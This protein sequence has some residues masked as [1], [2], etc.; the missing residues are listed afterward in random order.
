MTSAS[1]N[2]MRSIIETYFA[3]NRTVADLRELVKT[4]E[5]S[6]TTRAG[7]SFIDARHGSHQASSR[8]DH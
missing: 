8:S 6:A 2:V 4:G 3:L 1:R 7:R 5:E